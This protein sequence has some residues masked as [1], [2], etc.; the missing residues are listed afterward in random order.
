[1]HSRR[2]GGPR[3]VVV[4]DS[5]FMR[6]LITDVLEGDGIDVV[7][8]AA[9]GAK[10]VDAVRDHDPDVVTMDLEMPEV[11]GIEAVERIMADHPTP[12]VMLS[13]YTEEN[14]DVTF[15]AL[16]K[17]AVDF[18]A[19]PGGE[20]SAGLSRQGP[21][22]AETGR[23]VAGADLSAREGGAAGSTASAPGGG[24]TGTT[25]A[26]SA[27][28]TSAGATPAATADAPI[29][30]VVA[31]STGGPD[32]AE[33][34]V[35][36]LPGDADLRVLVVQHMP[37]G[38]TGRFAERLDDAAALDVREAADGDRIGAG[39]AL[40]APGDAHLEVSNYRRGRLRVS[41]AEEG[42]HG[43]G[44]VPAANV[45]MR[46][47]AEAVDD[48]L[49]GV[50]LTG[51]GSDGAD[52]VAAVGRAGGRVVAQNEETAVIHGMPGRAIETGHV[53]EVL[54]LDRVA[55]GVVQE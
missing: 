41:L 37:A 5:R 22:I 36:G 54:P 38:F 16:E 19:K 26:A 43:E 6:D 24:A 8:T 32:A 29:T 34:V 10:A 28:A 45:T 42:A 7:A 11:D 9:D 14:A 51:M 55:A 31:S 12:I 53:D 21:D 23:S 20:V 48:E 3:A 27:S 44:V 25:A 2:D 47:A 1:M 13:A 15:E 33:E 35:A 50:V 18:V 52:G 17:G 39:E 4:D 49:V 30:A 40:V 46:S